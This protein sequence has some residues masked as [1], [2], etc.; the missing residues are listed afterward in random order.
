MSEAD[1]LAYSSLNNTCRAVALG[2]CWASI[3][4]F[5]EAVLALRVPTG[6]RDISDMAANTKGTKNR[7]RKANDDSASLGDATDTEKETGVE[8]PQKAPPPRRS[9]DKHPPRPSQ[10]SGVP[11]AFAAAENL[12][13]GMPPSDPSDHDPTTYTSTL[14]LTNAKPSHHQI[15]DDGHSGF[16]AFFGA[17]GEISSLLDPSLQDF[18]HISQ[19]FSNEILPASSVPSPWTPSSLETSNH[20]GAALNRAKTKEGAK[21]AGDGSLNFLDSSAVGCSCFQ[22]NAELLFSFKLAETVDNQQRSEIDTFLQNVHEALKPWQNLVECRNCAN[23][24]DQE[25]LQIAFMTT[26]IALLRLQRLVPSCRFQ[27]SCSKKGAVDGRPSPVEEG[28]PPWPSYNAR[29]TLGTY[30]LSE[31]D[32]VM[33]IQVVL[34]SVIRKIKSIMIKFKEM[35]ERKKKMLQPKSDNGRTQKQWRS[36][37][38]DQGHPASNL[39]HLQHMLQGLASFLQTLEKALEKDQ[40]DGKT[41]QK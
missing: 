11:P 25:I 30:E 9:I 36:M 15:L 13:T 12:A 29:V 18:M 5:G 8:S 17:D 26:R 19:D 21:K 3:Y 40:P 37:L 20:Q 35:L 41:V 34:L 16:P 33:V 14:S 39:D 7:K 2:V 6:A 38:V 27:T 23:N 22:Q 10:A 28:D 32:N 31:A 1:S 4:H 24:I